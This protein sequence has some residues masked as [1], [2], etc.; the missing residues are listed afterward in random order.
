MILT[1][2]VMLGILLVKVITTVDFSSAIAIGLVEIWVA[3]SGIAVYLLL[4]GHWK[5]VEA[6]FRADP[7][8]GVEDVPEPMKSK[9]LSKVA[10]RGGWSRSQTFYVKAVNGDLVDCEVRLVIG[11]WVDHMIWEGITLHKEL[12]AVT[13]G[14]DRVTIK[15]GDEKPLT[16]WYANRQLDGKEWL[17]IPITFEPHI[18]RPIG[19]TEPPLI[20]ELYLIARGFRDKKPRRFTI[21]RESFETVRAE[22]G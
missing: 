17:F 3:S 7:P 8:M 18:P 13:I 9:L 6:H 20:L 22:P 12:S 1:P 21:Y 14:K 2:F 10:E 5:T 15:E 16:L 4:S 19:K 11:T